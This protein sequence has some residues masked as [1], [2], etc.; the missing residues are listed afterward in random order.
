M[1]IDI[2]NIETLLSEKKFDQVRDIIN[3]V[4]TKKFSGAEKGAV[5]AGLASVYLD[6]SNAINSRYRDALQQ[7]VEGMKEIN[8]AEAKSDER[9]KLAEVRNKLNS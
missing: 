1:E 3:S 7:A 2:N 9:I 8:A 6:I 4:V 5:L